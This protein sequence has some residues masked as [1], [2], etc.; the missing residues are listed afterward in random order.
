MWPLQTSVTVAISDLLCY[1]VVAVGIVKHG[2]SQELKSE[3]QMRFAFS[4]QLRFDSDTQAR[5]YINALHRRS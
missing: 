4:L 5:I 1:P 3:S 2:L